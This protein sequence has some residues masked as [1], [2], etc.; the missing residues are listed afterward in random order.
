MEEEEEPIPWAKQ[1]NLEPHRVHVMQTSLFRV[2]ELSKPETK[3][4]FSFLKHQ[5]PSDVH[6]EPQTRNRTSFAQ[7]RSKPPPRKYARISLSE[8]VSAKRENM[9]LDAGLSMGRSFRVGWGPGNKLVHVGQLSSGASSSKL[10]NSSEVG[11]TT[12]RV[13]QTSSPDLLQHLLSHSEIVAPSVEN[14]NTPYATLRAAVSFSSFS[15][16]FT[17]QDKS[18]CASVFRLGHA[19]FD[20]LDLHLQEDAPADVRN[21]ISALR[22]VDAL[23]AWLS[24]T[25]SSSVEQDIKAVA[26]NDSAQVAFLYLTGNQVEK[27]VEAL[28]NGGNVRLATIISQIPGDAEF[29]EDILEQLQIWKEEKEDAFMRNSIRKLYALAAGEVDVLEG[30]SWRE[31]IDVPKDLDWLRVLGLQLWY[32][33]SL[34]TPLRETFGVYEQIVQ[35]AHGRVGFPKP[36]YSTS[37][38]G[39]S[40]AKDG[41][42]NLMKLSVSSS[43]TLES[44][45]DP[46][47]FSSNPRDFRMSWFLYI[48]LAR[49]LRVRDFTDR[50]LY[51]AMEDDT[52]TTQELEGYSQVANA[53]T[54][55]FA[56]QLQQEGLVQEAAYV[57]LFLEDD[58]GRKRAIKELLAQ[59]APLL[60]EYTT[61][62]LHGSLRIPMEWIDE[63][64]ATHAFYSGDVYGAYELYR[65]AMAH[66]AAHEL[67]IT[68]LA[69]EA[70]LRDE[71]GVLKRLF[72]SLDAS[73]IDDFGVGG[74]LFIDYARIVS[75]V[76]KLKSNS[77]AADAVP[78]VAE[79]SELEALTG[80]IPQL[81]GVLPDVLHD[82][83]GTDDQCKAAL[84]HM[85][86]RLLECV[87]PSSPVRLSPFELVASNACLILINISDEGRDSTRVG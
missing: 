2:P 43:M 80:R 62:G 3:D 87:D 36:F 12:L 50:Q 28:M 1:L 75:R 47:S 5:R 23:S 13:A 42:F 81:I 19:L 78:D 16:L 59:S 31:N 9:F 15:S 60:N 41:L 44:A 24:R 56:A 69:P 51:D 30:S 83:P 74:Q 67:A 17:A 8:S 86:S 70:V 10:G 6:K 7:P 68:Y 40:E 84:S 79:Q 82:K 55:N 25:V 58:V 38:S 65:D 64:K 21:R 37:T 71:L 54:T 46:V 14:G 26:S 63:A 32:S 4:S 18:H 77:L 11:L 52:I 49:C 33:S 57:L 39:A 35:A 34:N 66:R 27:A 73:L 76:P 20:P 72:A 53:L 61:Q 22:R 85:L 45:L 48:L 29:R